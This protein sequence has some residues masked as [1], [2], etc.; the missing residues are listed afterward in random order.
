MEEL[1]LTRTDRMNFEALVRF[2]KAQCIHKVKRRGGKGRKYIEQIKEMLHKQCNKCLDCSKEF[3]PKLAHTMEHIIPRRY[4]GTLSEHNRCL[5]CEKCNNARN[6]QD[7][8]LII[9][10][11]YGPIDWEYLATLEVKDYDGW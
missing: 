10:T 11:H 6:F 8:T 5:L 1:Q 3:G 2:S 4:G 9:E 7:I